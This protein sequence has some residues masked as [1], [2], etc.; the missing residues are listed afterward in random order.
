MTVCILPREHAVR[1]PLVERNAASD[2]AAE[3]APEFPSPAA[4]GG[5]QDRLVDFMRGRS[6]GDRRRRRSNGDVVRTL[7]WR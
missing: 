3:A 2:L 1:F 4:V 7:I 6:V 5:F